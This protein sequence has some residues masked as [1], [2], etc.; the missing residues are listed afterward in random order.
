MTGTLALVLVGGARVEHVA[1]TSSFAEVAHHPAALWV[2]LPPASAVARWLA[3]HERLTL[4]VLAAGQRALARACADAGDGVPAALA[5]L[6]RG[7]GHFAVAGALSSTHGRVTARESVGDQ[8]LFL[9]AIDA[10][11]LDPAT[12]GGAPLLAEV[13]A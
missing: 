13:P 4:V 6:P 11:D 9:V 2:A 7:D 12:V 8:A 5:A 10:A 3:A 1:L